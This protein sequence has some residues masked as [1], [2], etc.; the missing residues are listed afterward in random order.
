MMTKLQTTEYQSR[1]LR[2]VY[3]LA[4]ETLLQGSLHPFTMTIDCLLLRNSFSKMHVYLRDNNYMSRSTI[5]PLFINNSEP[6]A[7][8]L[9]V[10]TSLTS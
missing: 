6:N 9:Y 1:E 10:Y 4:A 5:K 3:S 2:N 8:K 7:K